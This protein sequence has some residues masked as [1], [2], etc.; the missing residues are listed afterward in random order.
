MSAPKASNPHASTGKSNTFLMKLGEHRIE[1]PSVPSMLQNRSGADY[2][3]FV[4][5]SDQDRGRILFDLVFAVRPEI[6]EAAKDC[7][8]REMDEQLTAWTNWVAPGEEPLTK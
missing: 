5:A 3:D 2:L 8:W 4:G 1:M 6:R 7:S